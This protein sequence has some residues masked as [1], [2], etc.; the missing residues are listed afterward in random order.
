M[1]R[2]S[3]V[4]YQTHVNSPLIAWLPSVQAKMA[5]R[6]AVGASK[7]QTREHAEMVKAKRAKLL[8]DPPAP[9]RKS[10][11]LEGKGAELLQIW[12]TDDKGE[13][14]RPVRELPDVLRGHFVAT[15]VNTS[16]EHG[17]KF[18]EGIVEEEDE[19]EEREEDLK[20]DTTG[21]TAVVPYELN[22]RDI[23]KA[24]PDRVYS[25]ALHPRA[26]RMVIAAGDKLG[27]LALW[28]A[29]PSSASLG[30]DSQEPDVVVYRPH[31][32]P[33]TQLHFSPQDP[34][35]LVSASFDGCVREF[36]LRGGAFSELFASS[37]STGVT[38][39]ALGGGDHVGVYYASCDDGAVC[40]L[41]RRET[42]K[43]PA[44]AFFNLHEKKINTV[45]CHP[46][47]P[48]YVHAH[49]EHLT[50]T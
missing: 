1:P 42:P 13:R 19:A 37:D 30:D 24:L 49:A 35:K 34:T 22:E 29:P 47:R 31:T 44:A 5:A 21:A 8:E 15:A 33:I 12:Q 40:R 36:D 9:R 27:N 18:L 39:L 7:R 16:E 32:N 6:T 25:M 38:S 14:I 26:D 46:T 48:L 3:S 11:R 45:H 28:S 17:K 41:D 43:K 23:V 50:R 20:V 10:R 2:G 4:Q